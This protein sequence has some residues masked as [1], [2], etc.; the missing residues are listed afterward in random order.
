M[1]RAYKCDR[2][3]AFYGS[4]LTAKITTRRYDVMGAQREHDDLC[5][6][7]TED[8]RAWFEAGKKEDDES[9]LDQ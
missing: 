2:C 9:V 3:G 1:A 4:N 7:C 5:P 6:K 8:L